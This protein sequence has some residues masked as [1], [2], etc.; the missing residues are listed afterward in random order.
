MELARPMDRLVFD[1]LGDGAKILE[2]GCGGG[3]LAEHI[4]KR[5]SDVSLC[6]VDLALEQIHR[7][8]R[9]CS[10]WQDRLTFLQGSV[11]D[12]AFPDNCFDAIISV[13]SIKHW[14][15]RVHGLRECLRVLSPGGMLNIIEAERGCR[16]DSVR[17]F[18]DR[19]RIPGVFKPLSL[20]WFRTRV[21]GLGVHI[22][23]AATMLEALNLPEHRVERIDGTPGLLMSGRKA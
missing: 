19:W 1:F 18:V 16:L 7:A 2:V 23:E 20:F 3:H 15:D 9:R 4:A 5:R 8:K 6:G 22:D 11:L 14:P 17:A 10:A 21:A 13:A 12:L